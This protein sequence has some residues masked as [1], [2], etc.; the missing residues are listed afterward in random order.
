MTTLQNHTQE[1]YN[2][3]VA[4]DIGDPSQIITDSKLHRFP[5]KKSSWYI[6]HQNFQ[7]NSLILIFGSWVWGKGNHRVWKSGDEDLSRDELSGMRR[8]TK[9]ACEKAETGRKELATKAQIKAVYIRGASQ[10]AAD[11][12]PYLLRQ[13]VSAYGLRTYK[14][15]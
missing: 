9:A 6:C 5:R 12:Y 1:A 13:R 2:Q 10:P 14:G 15:A 4:A 11:D 7:Y 8:V 3:I